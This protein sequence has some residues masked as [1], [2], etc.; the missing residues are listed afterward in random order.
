M[1][2]HRR[3]LD[4]LL[5]VSELVERFQGPHGCSETNAFIFHFFLEVLHIVISPYSLYSLL[6]TYSEKVRGGKPG[7]WY[8][9]NLPGAGGEVG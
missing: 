4:S 8:G 2:E 5:E 1:G 7:T 6:F 9:L 3:L